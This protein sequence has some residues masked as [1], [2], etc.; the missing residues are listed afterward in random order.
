MQVTAASSAMSNA[1]YVRTGAS[2]ATVDAAAG[3]GSMA[4]EKIKAS[5]ARRATAA[6][7]EAMERNVP[8]SA[9]GASNTS[10]AQKWNG[11][12]ESL[13]A[14]PTIAIKPPNNSTTAV[15]P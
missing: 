2:T 7:F 3:N 10:G 6:A 4:P 9:G 1:R 11:T 15:D 8:T 14:S 5:R 13:K 12:A